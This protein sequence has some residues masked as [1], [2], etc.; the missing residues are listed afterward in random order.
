MV[1]IKEFVNRHQVLAE[2]CTVC[3]C[4]EG[5]IE[6]EPDEM[7][8]G[9]MWNIPEE[10]IDLPY[11]MFHVTKKTDP[12]E[13]VVQITFEVP[14]EDLHAA[15]KEFDENN[16]SPAEELDDD[17]LPW[18]SIVEESS[19]SGVIE[20]DDVLVFNFDF[21][22]NYVFYEYTTVYYDRNSRNLLVVRDGFNEKFESELNENMIQLTEIGGKKLQVLVPDELPFSDETEVE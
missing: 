11:A 22:D 1:R 16:G 19:D 15:L 20:V 9:L 5:I 14:E 21:E 4:P 13:H 12:E 6:R 18:E 2:T 10:L 7:W 3:I 8:L 17:V